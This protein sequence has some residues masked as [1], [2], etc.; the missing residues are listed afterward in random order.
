MET[1]LGRYLRH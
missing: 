1:Y